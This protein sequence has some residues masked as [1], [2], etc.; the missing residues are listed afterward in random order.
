MTPQYVAA[1]TAGAKDDSCRLILMLLTITQF[2]QYSENPSWRCTHC[3]IH[4]RNTIQVDVLKF[5]VGDQSAAPEFSDTVRAPSVHL[6]PAA[7]RDAAGAYWLTTAGAAG[8]ICFS[9]STG[10]G[11][12]AES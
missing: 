10:H 11:I 5:I 4:C 1:K 8:S 6:R 7:D 9:A 2:Y 3:S 12:G